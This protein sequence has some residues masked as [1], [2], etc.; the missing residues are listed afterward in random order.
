MSAT[1]RVTAAWR[2]DHAYL[3]AIAARILADPV[4]A[5]DVVQD[6]FARL[7][8]QRVEEIEDLRGWLVVV[9]RRIAMDRLGSAHRRLSRSS[10]PHTLAPAGPE[11]QAPDPADRVTLDDEVRRA[12]AV[13]LDQLSPAERATFL[14]HDVFGI[15]FEPI[16]ELVGRTPAACR[17]LASRARRSI[18]DSDPS[19]PRTAPAPDLQPVVDSFIAACAGGDLEA[20]TQTLHTDA[21]GWATVDGRRVGFAEGIDTVAARIMFFLG[22][23]SGWLLS[24]LP[25]D[26]GIAVVA[27]RNA[28]PVAM[29]RLNISDDRI[30]SMHAMLLPT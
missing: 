22:P 29:L 18:R 5:E 8:V 6:A 27:T 17:Q 12:L 9:V 4:E 30:R 19:A 26:D 13:V 24:P 28:E 7:A 23:R 10:D 14:L 21:A 16:A 3:I 1:D 2:E 11:A 25:L 20:L 15:S